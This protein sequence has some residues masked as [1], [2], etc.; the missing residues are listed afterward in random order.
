[1]ATALLG[2]C[3]SVSAG[4]LPDIDTLRC[5]SS[6]APASRPSSLPA[7]GQIASK[8][9]SAL[10]GVI[11]HSGHGRAG[12]EPALD[13]HGT[14]VKALA[15]EV[16]AAA[17][18]ACRLRTTSNAARAGYV[19]SSNYTEGVGTHWTNW[20]L[21]DKPFDPTRPSMLLYGPRRGESHLVGFSYWV[22]T[23]DPAGPA[24]FTGPDDHWHR[25]FGLGFDRVGFREREYLNSPRQCD[26][27]YLNGSDIWMLHAWIVPGA[28]NTWG[29][30]APLNPQLCSRSVADIVRCP[31]L[32]G[33]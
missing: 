19:R 14:A 32:R 26:G 25:Q 9:Q 23:A 11:V 16:R 7:L 10:H 31:G 5:A 24:G 18:I 12:P 28:A 13:V 30:F 33:P 6:S 21:V 29:V 8:E 3:S 27:V 22:R 4:T 20:G 15:D 17:R 2:A 1:V